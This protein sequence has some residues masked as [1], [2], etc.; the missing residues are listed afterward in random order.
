MR[1]EAGARR[2]GWV[3]TSGL[4]AIVFGVASIVSG[5]GVVLDIRGAREVAGT[6][7]G[8]VVWFNF[9][10]G[11]AYI[12]AGAG[13]LARRRWSA[14]LA[15]AIAVATLAVGFV[16]AGHVLLGGS[17]EARTVAAMAFRIAVWMA[18]ALVACRALDCRLRF[19]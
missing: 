18:I 13:L 12:A 16:F 4:M 17:Y 3:R 6:Y 11:F 1:D 8:F 5:G 14:L 10:A 19:A 9:L 7:V 15:A 2:S